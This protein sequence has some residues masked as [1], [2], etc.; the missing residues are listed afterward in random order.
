MYAPILPK[1]H[2]SRIQVCSIH[3]CPFSSISD[4]GHTD[5]E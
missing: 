3:L 1:C 5:L 2:L 4:T